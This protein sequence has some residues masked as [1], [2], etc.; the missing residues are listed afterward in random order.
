M[1][2]VTAEVDEAG[3][4]VVTMDDGRA[5]ALS[6]SLLRDLSDAL[7]LARAREARALLLE[8]RPG[9]FSTGIDLDGWL[10]M[11][12]KER[13]LFTRFLA[14]VLMRV[15]TFPRPVVAAV[16]GHAIAGGALLALA[17]DVR[18]C[19]EGGH[20]FAIKEVVLGVDLP[21]FGIEI[22]QARLAPPVRTDLVL[23]G[24]AFSADET[25]SHG[26]VEAV[27]APDELHARALERAHALAT[28]DSEAYA[29]TK[30]RLLGDVEHRV[31]HTVSGELPGFLPRLT[32]AAEAR[33]RR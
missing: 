11:D 31:E 6:F 24:R 21:S 14:K 27:V 5:N 29:T 9:R 26:I 7:D 33:A 12:D 20:S 10:A 25:L 23:L 2:A 19:A 17:A 30:A 32:R 18:L 1:G 22:A 28:L 8:G 15:L 16:T 4:A 3:V 13:A